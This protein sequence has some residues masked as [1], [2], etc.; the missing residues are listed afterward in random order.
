M[1]QAL[2]F[3]T[4]WRHPSH[5]SRKRHT[6]LPCISISIPAAFLV[7]WTSAGAAIMSVTNT[8]ATGPETTIFLI[9]APQQRKKRANSEGGQMSKRS[10]EKKS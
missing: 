5:V 8:V 10:H 1:P 9:H 7:V 3:F 4:V 6:F 2:G